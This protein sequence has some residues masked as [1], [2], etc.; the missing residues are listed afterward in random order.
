MLQ[1]H[2]YYFTKICLDN[3]PCRNVYGSMVK[4][5]AS[6]ISLYFRNTVP[7]ILLSLFRIYWIYHIA[8][9][10]SSNTTS[11]Q[12]LTVVS[13]IYLGV[14]QFT[15]NWLL[16]QRSKTGLQFSHAQNIKWSQILLLDLKTFFSIVPW[17][18]NNIFRHFKPVLFMFDIRHL[19]KITSNSKNFIPNFLTL[20]FYRMI[21]K[22]TMEQ[23]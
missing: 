7:W 13:E 19:K 1:S 11:G 12:Y 18:Y 20:V 2:L 15:L 16:I 4:V 8:S 22:L 14:L 21:L 6:I 5:I 9:N 10:I 23:N 3:V 17:Q